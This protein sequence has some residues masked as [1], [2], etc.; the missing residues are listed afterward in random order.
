MQRLGGGAWG[1]HWGLA[2]GGTGMVMYWNKQE[3]ASARDCMYI[4]T[5]LAP[6]NFGSDCQWN[7]GRA[8]VGRLRW[9]H[10]NLLLVLLVTQ[11]LQ[12]CFNNGGE[13]VTRKSRLNSLLIR[14]VENYN[15][16]DSLPNI[17]GI[18]FPVDRSHQ[19]FLK[20]EEDKIIY[21][22]EIIR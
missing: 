9:A 13:P 15:F 17:W 11:K 10:W 18:F 14:K 12:R 2:L 22:S 3:Q 5:Q 19:C 1:E 4:I 20:K 16:S 7:P 21:V 6:F 8:V